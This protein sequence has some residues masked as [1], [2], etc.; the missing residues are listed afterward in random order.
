MTPAEADA[1]SLRKAFNSFA[2]EL[3][4]IRAAT[5]QVVHTR[6]EDCIGCGC[7][8]LTAEEAVAYERLAHEKRVKELEEQ[9]KGSEDGKRELSVSRAIEE[10]DAAFTWLERFVDAAGGEVICGEHCTGIGGGESNNPWANALDVL[11]DACAERDKLREAVRAA[12]FAVMETSGAWSIH[13]VS[14]RGKAEEAKAL[15]VATRNVD[16]EVE[17]AKLREVLKPF[18]A[19]AAGVPDN[20]PGFCPLTWNQ[21]R[22][23]DETHFGSV[24]YMHADCNTSAP[25]IDDYRRAAEVLAKPEAA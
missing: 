4:R 22:L 5:G 18:A 20:W 6:H 13:D 1:A 10:V 25:K 16:L 7:V 19:V 11:R 3:D 24:S 23:R 14:E 9:V 21:E 15:E 8:Q 12:G 2:A 17:V